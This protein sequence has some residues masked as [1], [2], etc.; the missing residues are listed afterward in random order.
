LG[1]RQIYG[2]QVSLGPQGSYVLP[3]EDP[4]NVDKRRAAVG[5][6]PIAEYLKHYQIQWNVEQY[7]K[8]L[9]SIEAKEKA[10]GK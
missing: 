4:D 6:P 9:P 10:K 7:K 8:D 2:S 1:K 5:L 3:L